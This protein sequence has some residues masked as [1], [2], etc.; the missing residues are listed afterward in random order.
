MMNLNLNETGYVSSTPITQNSAWCQIFSSGSQAYD[1]KHDEL[2]ARA[3]R[4]VEIPRLNR[5]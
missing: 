5:P 4:T 3:V 1:G 2:K